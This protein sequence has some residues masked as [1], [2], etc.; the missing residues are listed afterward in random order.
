MIPASVEHTVDD[1]E[2]FKKARAEHS[3]RIA[4][5]A[6]PAEKQDTTQDLTISVLPS[7]G[8][9]IDSALRGSLALHLARS[10]WLSL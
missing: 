6:E 2:A 9:F 8:A 7:Q 4:E 5:L 1:P 10:L 3:K